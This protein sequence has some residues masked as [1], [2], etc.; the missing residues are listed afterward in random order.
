[1]QKREYNNRGKFHTKILG[2]F[3]EIAIFIWVRFL[4]A[5]SIELVQFYNTAESIW[6][7]LLYVRLVF[8]RTDFVP[9]CVAA[10]PN[11]PAQWTYD[12]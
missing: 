12:F 2:R 1:M 4:T 9:R 3:W 8:R 7:T 11:Y 5:S 6:S 10:E